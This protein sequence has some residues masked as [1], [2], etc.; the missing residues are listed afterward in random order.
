MKKKIL[1]IFSQLL[2][3][4]FCSQLVREGQTVVLKTRIRGNPLP[5]VQWFYN[6]CLIDLE[7]TD[8][9]LSRHLDGQYIIEAENLFGKATS[10]ATINVLLSIGSPIALLINFN[11]SLPTKGEG[12]K[13]EQKVENNIY[14]FSL[15]NKQ[16]QGPVYA[17]IKSEGS[18]SR[19]ASVGDILDNGY[20]SLANP[21]ECIRPFPSD[22]TINEG[23]K[24]EVDCMIIGNP[25]PKVQWFFNENQ[26]KSNSEFVQFSNIGDT[27]SIIFN[28]A[29]LECVGWYRLVAENIRG[30][31]ESLTLI[32]VRPKS[33]IPKPIG[34]NNQRARR[35]IGGVQG[36]LQ[37]QRQRQQINQFQQH[38]VRALSTPPRRDFE[39]K[40]NS[41]Y[42]AN[43]EMFGIM[44][45][46]NYESKRGEDEL[47]IFSN[48]FSEIPKSPSFNE[49]TTYIISPNYQQNNCADISPPHFT[50]TLISAILNEG[51]NVKFEAIVTGIPLPQIIWTKDGNILN[52][53]ER[54]IFWNDNLGKTILIINN[55]N[56]NDAGKYCCIA[57][58][59][60]GKACSSA[61]LVLSTKMLAP[62]FIERLVSKEVEVGSSLIWT[63][64]ASGDPEPKVKWF[65]DGN[66]I[67]TNDFENKNEIKI[68]K[69][70]PFIYSL[71]IDFIKK[72]HAGQFT[73]LFENIAGEARSTADLVVRPKGAQP[74]KYVHITK[75]TQE[76]QD[77]QI[78]KNEIIIL[79]NIKD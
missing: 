8:I 79:E 12:N 65:K 51:Q 75:S 69:D 15:Q 37:L 7:Q 18:E 54:I 70:S 38:Q 77:D 57:E 5:S 34:N 11:F 25:R 67:S 21:P 2:V 62:D 52:S 45:T 49:Q 66:L 43:A 16:N 78:T 17:L 76:R 24:A 55:I 74:G 61:Q 26:I 23:E 59:N 47:E 60:L 22:I 41:T 20:S 36:L 3:H 31:C 73:C 53:S 68:N 9:G 29:R 63:V 14:N 44:T 33:M 42:S 50:K 58:N 64:K 13:Q 72:E 56:N 10:T 48:E 19:R 71:K 27:Y 40:R 30:R 32:H 39:D 6:D 35:S 46:S 1:I 4:L 28:P